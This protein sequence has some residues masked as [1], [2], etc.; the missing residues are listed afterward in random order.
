MVVVLEWL[1]AG[2]ARLWRRRGSESSAAAAAEKKGRRERNGSAGWL[3]R[4]LAVM[5]ARPGAAWPARSGR[6]R[7]A[8][9]V[10][11]TR[12]AASEAGRPR[13][14]DSVRSDN[15]KPSLTTYFRG[16]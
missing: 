2:C 15:T 10:G 8:T 11:D 4:A 12:R 13:R 1:G 5:K 16:A 6:G 7:R 3:G 14:R 9:A